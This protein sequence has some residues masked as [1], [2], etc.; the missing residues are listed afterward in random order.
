MAKE[1]E[2]LQH[3]VKSISR[4]TG[5]DVE[6]S[7][8]GALEAELSAN[9]SRIQREGDFYK[10]MSDKM[11]N[12][13]RVIFK[14]IASA[15]SEGGESPS[16]LSDDP[17]GKAQSLFNEAS[18]QIDEVLATTRQAA[19]N[20]MTKTEDLLES[21]QRAKSLIKA[22]QAENNEKAQ[23]CGL[24]MAELK[25]LSDANIEAL[26][27]IMTELSFQ[28]L[29]GQRLKKVTDALGTIRGTVLDIYLS[30]GLMLKKRSADPEKD[31]K[32]IE[33][34]SRKEVAAIRNSEL[35]GP[36]AGRTQS[37]VDS[38]LAELGL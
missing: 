34:E 14:E 5:K 17:V 11:L 16:V 20:I 22:W 29:T 31:V 12:G 3:M 26:T 27:T 18:R 24:P 23:S 32:L 30:T 6:E 8:L 33:E 4:Q 10:A 37:D 28:D 36:S 25:R 1:D 9:L 35:K 15:T 7:L 19:D 21:N 38:L 13:L 2:L